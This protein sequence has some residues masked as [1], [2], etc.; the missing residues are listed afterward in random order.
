MIM[1]VA[2]RALEG[3]EQ[4]ASVSRGASGMPSGTRPGG[5]SVACPA[6]RWSDDGRKSPAAAGDRGR[7]RKALRQLVAAVR[8]ARP[9]RQD[10]HEQA[11]QTKKKKINRS[12]MNPAR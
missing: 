7:P 5:R 1:A 11:E 2:H 9:I 3:I 10:Q 6:G 4:N 8:P 12:G